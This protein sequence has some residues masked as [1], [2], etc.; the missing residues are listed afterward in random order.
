VNS[1]LI[2]RVRIVPIGDRPAPDGEVDVRIVGDRVV[3]GAP[4]VRPE[5]GDDVLDADGRW[6]LP[7]LWDQHVHMGQWAATSGR[8]DLSSTTSPDDAV[9]LVGA[10]VGAR[11]GGAA[12]TV[13]QGFGHRTAAW[14]RQPTV[15][16]LDAVSGDVPVVLI[17]GDA[18]HGWL[19]SAALRLLDVPPREG[20]VEENEWF[21]VFARLDEMTTTDEGRRTAYAKVLDAALRRGVV[22]V[23]DMEWAD[24]ATDWAQRSAD[25]LAVLRVRTATYAAGLADTISAGRRSGDVLDEAGLITMGPLK[26][27]SD[28]SLN[29]RTAFCHDPYVGDD[30][31]EFPRG[32]ANNSPEELADLLA[33]ATANGLE[34]AVHAIGDAAVGIALDAFS[35]TGA[36]GS[37]E[38]AQLVAPADVARMGELGVIAS[39]QPAHLLD[40]R[41]V[42]QQCWPDRADRCFP[43]RSMLDAGVTLALGSDA[44]VAPLDP[45]EAMAAAV[46]R[47]GDDREEWN[48][49]EHITVAQALAGSVD[50]APTVGVGSLA[51]LVLV[52]SDPCAAGEAGPE[53]AAHLRAAV[54]GA[55][56]IAG[57]VAFRL[58]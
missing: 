31:L 3:E 48:A 57:Q 54:V 45:W 44:P 34:V 37:I 53:A 13:I 18:H 9:R 22:G 20:V 29:T 5:A 19:N 28:G 56:V 27:I 35:H 24:N 39:V 52:D 21:P 43:L 11:R 14:D 1:L 33:R 47:T 42:T 15:A 58:G 40:D 41:D 6:L 7:G 50:G 23:R 30:V 36:R 8:L 16:E 38:H 32:R 12:G 10:E 51:D 46:H 4:H 17:S 55:T 25:G 49:G 2:R 26:I